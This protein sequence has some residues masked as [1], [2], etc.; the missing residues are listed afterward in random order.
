MLA[1]GIGALP[2]RRRRGPIEAFATGASPST[3]QPPFHVDDDVAPLK[4]GLGRY[5]AIASAAFHVDDDVAP[6]KPDH[7]GLVGARDRAF[8]VDD[9]VAPLKLSAYP[10]RTRTL[11]PP[12]TSTTTWPH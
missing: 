3:L 8:H 1:A 9:D 5:L 6:L 2:R 7:A 4:P 10:R 11:F 12:S